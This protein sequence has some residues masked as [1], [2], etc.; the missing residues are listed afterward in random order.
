MKKIITSVL[1]IG[2]IVA[3][4]VFGLRVLSPEDSWE[5]QDGQWQRHGNPSSPMPTTPC[6]PTLGGK[7]TPTATPTVES[8]SLKDYK[9]TELKFSAKIPQDF[10]TTN[11]LDNTVTISMWGPT[12]KTETEL[13]DGLSINV[14]QNSFGQNKDLKTIIDAD[15]VQKKEQ[16]GLDFKLTSPVAPKFGGYTFKANEVFGETVYYYLPQEKD[17]YLLLTVFV[18][19]PGNL[20]FEKAVGDILSSITMTK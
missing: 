5:C 9:N 20:G 18:R 4:V 13:Y 16:L 6:K 19:D 11:N 14:S 7:T 10:V 8:V 1:V 2:L 3:A 15:I 17:Q 12:Q